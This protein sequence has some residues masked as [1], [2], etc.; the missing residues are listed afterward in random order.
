M[1]DKLGMVQL[2]PR[3]N[4][5]LSS[6]IGV[7]KPFSEATARVIDDEVRAVIG[8]SHEQALR[9]LRAHR[10]ELDALVAALLARETLNEQ[11]VLAVTGL[12][13]ALQPALADDKSAAVPT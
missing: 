12:T 5:Y 3:Q 7:E 1:S 4:P 11:E 9:L 8:D 2:A 13:P 6:G 10:R